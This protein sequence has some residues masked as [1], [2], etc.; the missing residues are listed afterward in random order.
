MKKIIYALLA[1]VLIL[2]PNNAFASKETRKV[3]TLNDFGIKLIQTRSAD[4][5]SKNILQNDKITFGKQSYIEFDNEGKIKELDRVEENK[6]QLSEKDDYKTF[7]DS[8]INMLYE[9]GYVPTNYKLNYSDSFL[10]NG[11]LLS[12]TKKN[13]FGAENLYDQIRVTIDKSTNKIM[14]YKKINK[15]NLN[16][17]ANISDAKAKEIAKGFFES[18]NIPLNE[19]LGSKLMVEEKNNFYDY[20]ITKTVKVYNPT[21]IYKIKNNGLYVYIDAYSGKIV[22]GDFD[23]SKNGCAWYLGENGYN[24]WEDAKEI[25]SIMTTLGYK[26]TRDRVEVD[27]S[28]VNTVRAFLKNTNSYAFSFSGHGNSQSIGSRD[29]WTISYNE[30]SGIWN[31][32]FLDACNTGADTYLSNAFGITNNS[33]NKIFLGWFKTVNGS[34][35]Y[36]YVKSLNNFVKKYPNDKFYN[37]VW[38][39]LDSSEQYFPLRFRGDKKTTGRL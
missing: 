37:N 30:I 3:E 2:I 32:V 28:D 25:Q 9:K 15:Y 22:G 1:F 10:D 34:L 35:T 24:N 4:N 33:R 27:G 20:S 16:K 29:G 38:K 13:D 11:W 8:T 5:K 17:P 23:K 26:A 36:N 31:F 21:L 19:T 7:V 14:S 39:A 18:K 12:F 6:S